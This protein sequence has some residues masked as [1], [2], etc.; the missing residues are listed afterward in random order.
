MLQAFFKSKNR[1]ALLRIFFGNPDKQ[2]YIR[3]LAKM[4]EASAGNTDKELKKLEESEI[5]FSQKI[6]NL[7]MYQVKKDNPLFNELNKIVSKTIGI[8]SELIKMMSHLK[9]ADFAFIFG[10]YVKGGFSANS[11][12]DLFLIGQINEDDLIRE[13]KKAERLIGREINFHLAE[14]NEFKKLLKE[15][16]F[17]RDII[18]N[19]ILLTANHDKFEKFITGV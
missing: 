2:Y 5:I 12:I 17:Y 15:K 6:G 4:I 9:G 18:K 13:I 10:S 16:S 14:K 1:S 19:Y 8:E 3:E 7:R 11:D